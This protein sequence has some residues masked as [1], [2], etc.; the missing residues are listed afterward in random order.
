MKFLFVITNL[1]GG[2][3]EKVFVNICS[4]LVLAGHEATL[5]LLENKISYDVPSNVKIDF[6]EDKR[7]FGGWLRKILLALKLKAKVRK[8][9]Y[10]LVVST[11]PYADEVCLLAGLKKHVCR[12]AN[13]LSQE[14]NKSTKKTKIARK[15]NKIKKT[16]KN[17]RLVAVSDGVAE[18]LINNFGFLRKNIYIIYNSY[19]FE[20]IRSLAKNDSEM[21][22][23]K[24]Y[25][26]HVGRFSPQKRH[27]VLFEA[28]L[29]IKNKINYNLVLL[30]DKNTELNSLIVKYGLEDR[31]FVAGFHK[32]P[33]V[34]MSHAKLVVLSSD[35]EGLPNVLIESLICGQKVV[36]T[37]CPSGPKEIMGMEARNFLVP[38]GDSERLAEVILEATLADK[39]P[40]VNL[41]RFE[42]KSVLVQWEKL[43]LESF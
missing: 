34:W 15:I 13:N 24:P 23:N 42:V 10:D 32:N 17:S 31:V 36:S 33:Y 30:A 29:K 3:A 38:C 6:I 14:V 35:Y 18:D 37:D 1:S 9:N 43:A 21:N 22:Y 25:I 26:L 4:N 27:D 11:L 39:F 7:L 16:Y 2:G 12:I 40:V 28:F 19:N 8:I 5:L 41:E 20:Y